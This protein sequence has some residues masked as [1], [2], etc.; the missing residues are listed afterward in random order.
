MI[1]MAISKVV[2][3]NK[4]LVDLTSDTVTAETLADGYTAHDAAGNKITGLAGASIDGESLILNGIVTG[5]TV[6]WR[7]YQWPI[8][9]VS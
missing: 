8:L 1:T 4:T 5:E 2:Y 6:E 7:Y 3:G 9:V